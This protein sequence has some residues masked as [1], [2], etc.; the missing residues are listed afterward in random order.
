MK[1]AKLILVPI[2]AAMAVMTAGC[3]QSRRESASLE[4]LISH[5]MEARG[6][7]E[8]VATIETITLHGKYVHAQDE[9]PFSEYYRPPYYLAEAKMFG[10][11]FLQ[12][13]DGNE[14]WWT[15]PPLDVRNA[16]KIPDD[17]F[18]SEML[19]YNALHFGG[20]T[21]FDENGEQA[22]L[23]GREDLDGRSMYTVHVV[24]SN[25]LEVWH[26]ID[27]ESFLEARRVFAMSGK[28]STLEGGGMESIL[29]HVSMI[30]SDYRDIDG[31]M[32]PHRTEYWGDSNLMGTFEVD[33]AE[34]NRIIDL[35]MFRRPDK[36]TD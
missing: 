26:H 11:R 36:E 30:F 5:H 4:D 1:N 14:T 27:P 35:T 3:D 34:F 2:V 15:I 29:T 17:D 32:V 10:Q 8:R 21:T 25:G 18:R 6:G 23:V 28:R 12:A 22:K 16:A 24:S 33:E 9:M 13:Y 20:L 7:A 19:P 31:V